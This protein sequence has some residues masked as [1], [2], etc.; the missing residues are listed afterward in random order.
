MNRREYSRSESQRASQ[1]GEVEDCPT[2]RG[3][4]GKLVRCVVGVQSA[5]KRRVH[6][7]RTESSVS[8]EVTGGY[9][10]KR[11]IVHETPVNGCVYVTGCVVVV[12]S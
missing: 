12:M 5:V 7:G 8:G 1:R 10:S 3:V 6:W 4:V 9:A 11:L 2:A